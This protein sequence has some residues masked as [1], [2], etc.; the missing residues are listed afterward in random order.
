MGRRLPLRAVSVRAS[1]ASRRSPR[2]G[3]AASATARHA[4]VV[5]LAI[6]APLGVAH[7]AR[8]GRRDRARA[9]LGGLRAPVRGGRRARRAAL[10]VAVALFVTLMFVSRHDALMTSLL[11]AY[12]AALALWAARRLGRRALRDLDAVRATLGAV[13]EGRRDV[14]TGARPATTRSP[15]SAAR[16]TR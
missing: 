12:A 10:A 3:R 16:W 1:L 2:R 5:T 8:R 14:R 4:G 7:R 9:R 11:A 13:G 6:V 15:G